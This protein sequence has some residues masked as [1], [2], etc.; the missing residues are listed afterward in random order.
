MLYALKFRTCL[1]DRYVKKYIE[2]RSGVM[3]GLL[4]TKTKGATASGVRRRFGRAPGL[5][6]RISVSNVVD[7]P[8]WPG[9]G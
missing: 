9:R 8:W 1:L 4:Q 6:S 7:H 2:G 5:A 3:H